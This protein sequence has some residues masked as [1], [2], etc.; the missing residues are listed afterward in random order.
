MIMRMRIITAA[1]ALLGALVG[2]SPGWAEAKISPYI[3]AQQVL[4]AEF[5]NGG[6]VL[7]YTTL[8][9]GVDGSITGKR[10]EAQISYRY[11]HRIPWNKGE[12]TDSVHNGL[13]RARTDVVPKLISLE[14]GAI[15]M[16]ARSDIRGDAPAFFTG[17]DKNLTQVYGAY[18]GPNLTAHAG[19]VFVNGSYRFGYIK[20]DDDFS[21]TLPSGQPLLDRYNHA[22]SHEGTLSV[23]M[24]SGNLPF[25]WTVTG[26]YTQENTSQLD[27]RFIGKYVRGDVTVPVSPHLALTGGAGYEDIRVTERAPLRDA[28][29]APILGPRGRF[30]TDPASPRLL[31]YNTDGL[32]WDVG[33]IWKPN[34][35]TTVQVRGGRRYGGRAITGSVDYQLRRTVGLRVAV[36]DAIESFGRALTGGLATLPTSFDANRDPL[37]GDFGGCVFG[38]TPGT[39]AC[40]DSALQSITTANYRSRGAYALLSGQ[41]GP[42]TFGMG[43]GYANHKYLAPQVAQIFTINGVVDESFSLQAQARRSLSSTSDITGSLVGNWYSSGIGNAPNVTNIGATMTYSRDFTERLVGFGGVGLYNYRIQREGSSTHGQAV[44]G[45]RYRF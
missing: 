9:A 30:I 44:V 2:A 45:V 34:R 31:G 8:A 37:T 35:R 22:T 12:S 33:A 4:D 38:T 11:E 15:A 1:V 43:A 26:G 5:N 41:R 39:G 16:R 10:T 6:E 32:I 23:G 7:T 36:Y 13:A 17:S 24:P 40:L 18:V 21:V 42:W 20:V 3:E 29:G 25:G 28:N 14:G 19:P 27:Q